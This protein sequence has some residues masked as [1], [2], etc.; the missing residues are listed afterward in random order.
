MGSCVRT[1]ARHAAAVA[2]L[3]I[4]GSP[5]AAAADPSASPMGCTAAQRRDALRGVQEE[6]LRLAPREVASLGAATRADGPL[7]GWQLSHGHVVLASAGAVAVDNVGMRGP[8]PLV[9][10]YAPSPSS[11]PEAWLDWD[12]E[13]GPYRLVGWSHIAPWT[14]GSSPPSRWCLFEAEWLVHEA[15]WHTKDGGMVLTPEATSEPPRPDLKAGVHFW[16]PRAWAIHLW[17]GDD[18]LPTVTF[19]NPRAPGG[20][21]RLPEGAFFYLVNGRKELPPQP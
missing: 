7:A 2:L 1:I 4:L 5:A 11:P 15:G 8:M 12:G 6:V 21:L 3:A 9:L 13:D 16:H 14:P 10:L 17:L 18:G 19:H 20:G